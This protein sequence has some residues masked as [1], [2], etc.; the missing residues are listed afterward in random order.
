MTRRMI[1]ALMAVTLTGWLLPVQASPLPFQ[2][3][4][5]IGTTLADVATDGTGFTVVTGERP[6]DEYGGFLVAAFDR[7]GTK[8]WQDVWKPIRDE[9]AGTTGK[10]VTIGPDGNVYV[11]GFGWHCLYGCESGGWFIR[12]YARDGSLR[13]TRQA[14]GWKTRPRQSEATGID[15]WSGGLAI[16]GFEYDDMVGPTDSWIRAYG[17]DGAFAWKTRVRVAAGTDV[18]VATADLAIGP[19]GSLFVAGYVERDLGLDTSDQESF[20][21]GFGPNGERRWTRVIRERGDQDEDAAVAVD[22]RG[23]TLVV[24]GELCTHVPGSSESPTRGWLSQ[25]S[26]QGDVRWTQTWGGEQT[27]DVEDVALA[28]DG[29]VVTIGSAG[30]GSFAVALVLRT[31][32]GSGEPDGRQILD[33][34]RGGLRGAGVAVDAVGASLVGNRQLKGSSGVDGRLWRL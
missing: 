3:R 10:A 1:A 21:A 8:L 28:A 20:I 33:P 7:S 30:T 9:P 2:W 29:K 6:V 27:P 31:F 16:T 14:A 4:R 18:R 19:A 12:A 24:A 23:T 11:A 17:L 13:W 25:L 15:S 32:T 5:A 34:V 26:L 22:V